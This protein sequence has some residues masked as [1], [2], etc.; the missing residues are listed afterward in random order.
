MQPYQTGRYGSD[1]GSPPRMHFKIG[2]LRDEGDKAAGRGRVGSGAGAGSKGG[3]ARGQE[4]WGPWPRQQGAEGVPRGGRR[5]LETVGDHVKQRLLRESISQPGIG[6][7]GQGHGEV[8]GAGSRAG[9][10]EGREAPEDAEV[11]SLSLGLRGVHHEGAHQQAVRAYHSRGEERTGAG[12]SR[13]R[14]AS[15]AAAGRLEAARRA[16]SALAGSPPRAGDSGDNGAPGAAAQDWRAAGDRGRGVEGGQGERG[17]SPAR[18]MIAG[19]GRREVVEES[20]HK[21][22]L[23]AL[24]GSMRSASGGWQWGDGY[25]ACTFLALAGWARV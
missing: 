3:A 22:R 4:R 21:Q 15:P 14:S 10:E 11:A 9:S 23:D 24:L 5:G 8:G 16:A 6:E 1:A 2:L 13:G 18:S 19:G 7:G 17:R 12:S 25:A 20:D